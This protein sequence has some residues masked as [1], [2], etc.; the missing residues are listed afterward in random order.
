MNVPRHQAQLYL[1]FVPTN[2]IG[3]KS[4]SDEPIGEEE[5]D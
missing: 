3:A 2:G 1:T 5:I 4:M